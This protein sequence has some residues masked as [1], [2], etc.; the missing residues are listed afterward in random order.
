MKYILVPVKRSKRVNYRATGHNEEFGRA[1]K[2]SVLVRQS[3]QGIVEKA[4]GC[5][6]AGALNKRL[7]EVLKTDP[8]HVYGKRTVQDGDVTLLEG[9]AF[10]AKR[11]LQGLIHQRLDTFVDPTSGIC[12][13]HIPALGAN[14]HLRPG[15]SPTHV[16]Y[17]VAAV[18]FDFEKHRFEHALIRSAYLAMDQYCPFDLTTLVKPKDGCP[19]L[20]FLGIEFFSTVNN[21]FF[22]VRAGG[23]P[24]INLVRVVRGV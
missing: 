16:R 10:N 22:P 2:A 3:L 12:R 4:P 17:A 5:L 11:S 19:I 14:I 9:Y 20:V 24:C 13:V 7:Y 21:H 6:R 1:C 23:G 15:N 8:V 18:C